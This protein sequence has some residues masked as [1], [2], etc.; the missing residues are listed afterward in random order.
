VQRLTRLYG[1]EGGRRDAEESA[2]S[3]RHHWHT[4]HRA[5]QIDEP[6]WQ[7]WRHPKKQ[8]IVQ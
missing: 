2:D 8:H 7:Q 5:G 1:D 4:D 3:K 6:V